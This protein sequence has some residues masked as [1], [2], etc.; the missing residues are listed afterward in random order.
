M[1]LLRK[2][3]VA[4]GEARGRLADD[5]GDGRNTLDEKAEIPALATAAR[6]E[7]ACVAIG[8]AGCNIP[9]PQ[10]LVTAEASRCSKAPGG[11]DTTAMC[12]K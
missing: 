6:G 8:V 10:L 7:L 12:E 4:R 11:R 9:G 3:G 1:T 5:V 2:E